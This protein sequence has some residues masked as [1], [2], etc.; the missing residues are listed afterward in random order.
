MSKA[1]VIK[2]AN[3]AENA[4]TTIDFGSIPCTAVTPSVETLTG[5]TYKQV[6]NFGYTLTPANTTDT[7]IISN[8]DDTV[9][10]LDGTSVTVIGVGTSTITIT[11]GNVSANITL[12]ANTLALDMTN[13]VYK[14]LFRTG[15]ISG[16]G[17]AT[18]MNSN[19]SY[20]SL[21][22]KY[23]SSTTVRKLYRGDANDSELIPLPNNASTLS[24]VISTARP[25]EAHFAD[26]T[27]LVSTYYAS[28]ISKVTST[29][30]TTPSFV[31]PEGADC[32]GVSIDY[33][34]FT[35]AD[36]TSVSVS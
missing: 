20:G 33:T 10:T 28:Y 15:S 4:L 26:S 34:T 29:S 11:C 3:F 30:S 25:T 9:C 13:M 14:N 5:T 16:A 35:L 22:E 18:Q 36:I 19:N 7:V 21:L 32:F 6:L 27:I 23:D 2:G 1:L 12:T 31:I 8:S 17:S 24:L